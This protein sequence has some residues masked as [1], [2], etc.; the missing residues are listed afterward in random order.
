MDERENNINEVADT[1]GDAGTAG[2][3]MSFGEWAENV[4]Y[5]YKWHILSA[6]F[7]V[8]VLAICITQCTSNL[9][10]PSGT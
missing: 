5:H 7:I 3:K 10:A 2:H 6:I 8:V 4:W 9:S 1:E